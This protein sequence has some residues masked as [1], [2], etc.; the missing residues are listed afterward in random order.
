MK[1]IFLLILASACA[2]TEP[3]SEYP[4]TIQLNQNVKLT[5][6]KKSFADEKKAQSVFLSNRLVQQSFYQKAAN[7]YYANESESCIDRLEL[8]APIEQLDSDRQTYSLVVTLDKNENLVDC[9]EIIFW[10]RKDLVLSK[11]DILEYV[12]VSKNRDD[13]QS[14][15]FKSFK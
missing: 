15:S 9:S 4:K 1:Y 13:I 7:P 2:H 12:F 10:A 5:I 6:T 3:G 11:N 14:L 8:N